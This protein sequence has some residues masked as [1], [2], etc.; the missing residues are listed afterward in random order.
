ML[1]LWQFALILILKIQEVYENIIKIMKDSLF[2]TCAR[3]LEDILAEE[4][5]NFLQTQPLIKV[6]TLMAA[7]SIDI[8]LIYLRELMHVLVNF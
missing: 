2:V 3:G 5:E 6:C 1:L 8:K 7:K 4:L